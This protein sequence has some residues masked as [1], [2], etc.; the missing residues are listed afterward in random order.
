MLVGARAM[1]GMLTHHGSVA[2]IQHASYLHLHTACKG[3]HGGLPLSLQAAA[4]S[5]LAR[6]HTYI[7]PASLKRALD[8]HSAAFQ[9]AFQQVWHPF[10]MHGA[11]MGPRLHPQWPLPGR[12]ARSPSGVHART[13]LQLPLTILLVNRP[14]PQDAHELFCGLLDL[15]QSEVLAREVGSCWRCAACLHPP[16]A[17]RACSTIRQ[18]CWPCNQHLSP[19]PLKHI[20]VQMRR[21]G[22]AQVRISETA[23]PAARNFSFAV[24][25]AGG[26]SCVAFSGTV[27]ALWCSCLAVGLVSGDAPLATWH[28]QAP[29]A[30]PTHCHAFSSW[31]AMHP[32]HFLSCLCRCSTS[33]SAARAGAPA[34]WLKNTCTCR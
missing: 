33:W 28:C 34:G 27:A 30:M 32:S 31:H 16:V 25:P 23:D 15:L 29:I 20:T 11:A 9:G 14:F 22:R 4:R 10:D 24:S 7:T 17:G 8:A 18:L 1:G 5:L 3:R 13:L 26:L 21:L 2:C 19:T 6:S 12:T